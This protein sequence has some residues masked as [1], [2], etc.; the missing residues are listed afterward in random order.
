MFAPLNLVILIDSQKNRNSQNEWH[1][2]MKGF[3]VLHL[4]QSCLS[5]CKNKQ[6]E[7][8][9]ENFLAFLSAAI[10][11]TIP[12]RHDQ[13]V[14]HR[15]GHWTSDAAQNILTPYGTRETAF[16]RR[17]RCGFPGRGQKLKTAHDTLWHEQQQM[18][19]NS[20]SHTCIMWT[21][22][23]FTL[24]PQAHLLGT[25]RLWSSLIP[26]ATCTASFTTANISCCLWL[27]REGSFDQCSQLEAQ[28]CPL[29]SSLW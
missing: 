5:Y 24:F 22:F 14:K 28:A 13:R 27:F 26:T 23:V 16:W 20:A 17:C 4:C 3:T 6:P 12:Q 21:F 1:V 15:V 18:A 10:F 25:H 9:F 8:I 29:L 19:D 2:N 11:A 7:N